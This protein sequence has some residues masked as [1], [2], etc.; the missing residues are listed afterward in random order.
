MITIL[1]CFCCTFVKC[2]RTL[3]Y[4]VLVYVDTNKLVLSTN[5]NVDINTKPNQSIDITQP[6]KI[7]MYTKIIN[8]SN[9]TI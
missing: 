5:P 7:K 4:V 9:K 3:I 6:T 8:S 2:F 1:C